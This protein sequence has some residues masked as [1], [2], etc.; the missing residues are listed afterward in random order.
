MSSAD[1]D[2]GWKVL[3]F[4]SKQRE[5]A[6]RRPGTPPPGPE[7]ENGD[8]APQQQQSGQDDSTRE[9]TL[10]ARRQ[11]LKPPGRIS[12][13]MSSRSTSEIGK[14]KGRAEQESAED[15]HRSDRSA[16][17][18]LTTSRTSISS[19]K[20]GPPGISPAAPLDTTR[21]QVFD[22]SSIVAIELH[23][24]LR[25]FPA[26]IIL[27][28]HRDL[29]ASEIR[30]ARDHAHQACKL[31]HTAFTNINAALVGRCAF[32]IGL[33]EYLYI[34]RDQSDIP[35]SAAVRKIP[36]TP[37]SA[38]HVR[39]KCLRWFEQARDANGVYVE[40]EWAEEWIEF[41]ENEMMT[42][43]SSPDR[44][45]R[46]ESAGSWSNWR[47][48]LWRSNSKQAQ[49]EN[50]GDGGESESRDGQWKASPGQLHEGN[51][52]PT[53]STWSSGRS[54]PPTR[55]SDVSAVA[56]RDQ[57]FRSAG[58]NAESAPT[59]SE[60]GEAKA[61]P[62]S[63]TGGNISIED[64]KTPGEASSQ[65]LERDR[66]PTG[67]LR[68]A[69]GLATTPPST[70]Q[71]QS[72]PR[73]YHITNPD[74]SSPPNNA[75][76]KSAPASTQTHPTG[77]LPPP[78]TTPVPRRHNRAKT[79]AFSSVAGK[80]KSGAGDDNSS[81]TGKSIFDRRRK[82][83]VLSSLMAFAT[84]REQRPSE[85]SLMEEGQSPLQATFAFGSDGD[86]PGTDSG[87]RLTKRKG[88]REEVEEMV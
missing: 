43:D 57:Q 23:I 32:Y 29:G 31:A 65:D 38:K 74:P 5:D 71:Q 27:S 59:S 48:W 41:V 19:G 84:I 66:R 7:D 50:A 2:D 70:M 36:R 35:A 63:A 55:D 44:P 21:R 60:D 58:Q 61:L 85:A 51:R 76:T 25:L 26:T 86:G 53:F 77:L 75:A 3:H 69:N 56:L 6:P 46:P 20:R 22:S 12:T 52:V 40:A 13:G 67:A 8:E 45:A 15:E 49:R 33:A 28:R 18:R 47:N 81:P 73:R 82:S 79:I 34:T 14:E 1:N 37:K 16:Q 10:A 83:S 4:F 54:R 17:G 68:I 39:D 30:E 62:N 11:V 72:P 9:D 78:V 42:T 87:G 80:P 88:I 24:K 64:F